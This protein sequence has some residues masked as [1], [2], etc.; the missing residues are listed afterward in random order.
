MAKPQSESNKPET[1]KI[2]QTL[3]IQT[4]EAIVPPAPGDTG[5][6]EAL[7]S[8][9][10]T[11][12][13][14]RQQT[15]VNIITDPTVKITTEQDKINKALT[16]SEPVAVA[17]PPCT[18]VLLSLIDVGSMPAGPTPNLNDLE[19]YHLFYEYFQFKKHR[20]VPDYSMASDASRTTALTNPWPPDYCLP[21]PNITLDG[22]RRVFKNTEEKLYLRRLFVADVAYLFYL[23]WMGVFQMQGRILEEFAYRGGIPLSNGSDHDLVKDDIVTMTLEAM[24]RQTESGNSSKVRD[25]VSTYR[26]VLGWTTDSGRLLDLATEVNTGFNTQLHKFIYLALQF[27]KDKRLA[28]AIR[29]VNAGSESVTSAATLVTISGTLSLLK[30]SFDLFRFGRNYHNALSGLVWAISGLK[31]IEELRQ[32][33]GIPP[34]YKSPAEFIPAAYDILVLKRPITSGESN[35]FETYMEC[36]RNIRDLLLDIE[37]LEYSNT[38]PNG[39]L[40]Q[41]LNVSES[42]IEGYRTAYRT[43][44]GVDL[45]ESPDVT[46]QQK[47]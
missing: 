39:T 13:E 23:E 20:T 29:G 43:L 5:N 8:R 44:T 40:E 37:V 16:E 47:V 4:G 3:P 34:E 7:F 38:Q 45:G 22:N 32:T 15:P 25:R 14:N 19:V 18:D 28:V 31:M 10:I 1:T 42:K 11:L 26:R 35:R 36:A 21:A 24:T 41:W 30:K 6:A 46:I 27:F 9:L 2:T 33:I 17:F 12:L